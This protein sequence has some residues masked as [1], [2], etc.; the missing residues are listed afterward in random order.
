[1]RQWTLSSSR[2]RCSRKIRGQAARVFGAPPTSYGEG[3][4]SGNFQIGD[5]WALTQGYA[6]NTRP[7][8]DALGQGVFIEEVYLK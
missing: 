4:R 7:P 6:G 5:L 3:F 1:M 2:L 8:C